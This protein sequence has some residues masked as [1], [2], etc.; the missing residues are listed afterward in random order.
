[1]AVKLVIISSMFRVNIKFGR[2]DLP[3]EGVSRIL[4]EVFIVEGVLVL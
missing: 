1:M 4:F 2:R 3:K